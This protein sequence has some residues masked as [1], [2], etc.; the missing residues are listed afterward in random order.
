MVVARFWGISAVLSGLSEAAP[1]A[2]T[3]LK[4]LEKESHEGLLE[5][6]LVTM[7]SRAY[8][9][10]PHGIEQTYCNV[11]TLA[12]V[13]LYKDG[14]RLSAGFTGVGPEGNI[15]YIYL[16]HE[17]NFIY[18][19]DAYFDKLVEFVDKGTPSTRYQKMVQ[20]NA[21]VLPSLPS[22]FIQF[23]NSNMQFEILPRAYT[24]CETK[25]D[26]ANRKCVLLVK[27]NSAGIWVLGKPFLSRVVTSVPIGTDP[28]GYMKIC[29][30]RKPADQFVAAYAVDIKRRLPYTTR[31]YLL[32]VA[33]GLAVLL[34]ILWLW[35][36]KFCPCLKRRR[37][38]TSTTAAARPANPPPA[39]S[40]GVVA[41]PVVQGTLVE[42][43]KTPEDQ[44][45]LL[46]NKV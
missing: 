41:I 5:A 23:S 8:L 25:G 19:P 16:A 20:F 7:N 18:M 22:I 38:Q 40:A 26:V 1:P 6:Q 4:A 28:R 46:N 34:V 44:Q 3:N 43:K 9:T 13:Y 33:L 29:L 12:Q 11:D 35:S 15:E 32:Y 14:G 37:G 24:R 27:K 42:G 36:D 2:I 39:A 21:S 31:D 17:S 30:P 45:P 10:N